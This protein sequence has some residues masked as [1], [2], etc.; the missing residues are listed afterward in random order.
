MT[1]HLVDAYYAQAKENKDLGEVS[2]QVWLVRGESPDRPG[3]S[4]APLNHRTTLFRESFS[5]KCQHPDSR[6][7]DSP[8]SPEGRLP[9]RESRWRGILGRAR[10]G[11]RWVLV[12][13]PTRQPRREVQA[14]RGERRAPFTAGSP[15]PGVLTGCEWRGPGGVA[16]EVALRV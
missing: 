9:G 13:R 4:Q 1:K 10:C 8:P 12:R 11:G 2:L 16:S 6:Q 14:G 15:G 7:L 3:A 5:H